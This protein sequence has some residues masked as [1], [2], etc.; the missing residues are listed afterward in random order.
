MPLF[1]RVSVVR[2]LTKV[3]ITTVLVRMHHRCTDTMHHPSK[4]QGAFSRRRIASPRLTRHPGEE[5]TGREKGN[6]ASSMTGD[7]YVVCTSTLS[8]SQSTYSWRAGMK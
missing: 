6:L 7:V 1:Q 3:R 4:E 8:C 2:L 5:A